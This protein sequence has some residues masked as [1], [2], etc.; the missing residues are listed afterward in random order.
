M[1]PISSPYRAFCD[2]AAHAAHRTFVAAP[3]SARLPWAPDG[4]SISYG[5]AAEQVE[6]LSR[7]YAMRG[8]G[9]G[10]RIALLLQNRP[11]FL[12]HWLALNALGASI[13]PLNGDL[14]PE[15]LHHQL[16][17]SQ[18]D[19]LI[20]ADELTGLAAAG[21]PEGLMV[22]MLGMPPPPAR[23][24]RTPAE[25]RPADEAALLF[26]SGSTGKPKACILSNYYFMNVAQWYVSMR[27]VAAMT[28]FAETSLTPLPF[29]HMNALGCTAVGMMLIGGAIVPLDRFHPSRWWQTIRDSGATIVHSLGVIP[30]ILLQQPRTEAERTHGARFTF[31]PGVRA[32]H[33]AAFE[34]RFALPIVEG[35][36]MTETGG[37]AVTDTAGETRT[38]GPNCIGRPRPGMEWRIIDDTGTPLPPGMAGE[39]LVRAAGNDPRSGFFS[40]YLNEPEATEEAWSGGW[41]HTGDIVS[42]DR[43]GLLYFVDRKKSVIRR[44]GENISALEVEVVLAA[45]PQVRAVAVTPVPDAVR[46]EEVFAFIVPAG[47]ADATA[48]LERA[49]ERL[50]YHKLP[51]FVMYVDALPVSSTEKLRRGQIRADAEAAVAA[52]RALELGTLKHA[53]RKARTL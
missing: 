37:A 44:S 34:A 29:F 35:W 53:L 13:V 2:S 19:A 28:P 3:A 41:F 32:N 4:F 20:V 45:D 17:I 10:S 25:S 15:E 43:D 7:H 22:A 42:A 33:K 9:H 47:Q 31:G 18:A 40:G 39:L 11:D 23:V 1:Q 30:A 14:R 46:E 52:G 27:G 49:A 50:S 38:L 6:M 12:I 16:V 5:R 8:Y 51:A 24:P 48:L 21:A 26:T 36:A